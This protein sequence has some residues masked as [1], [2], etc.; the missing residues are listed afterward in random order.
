MEP[1]DISVLVCNYCTRTNIRP[2]GNSLLF[3][4]VFYFKEFPPPSS[5]YPLIIFIFQMKGN[6][7]EREREKN[8]APGLLIINAHTQ[9]GH[10]QL[11]LISDPWCTIRYHRLALGSFHLIEPKSGQSPQSCYH[12][13][14]L[15][16]IQAAPVPLLFLA[17]PKSSV[18][19]HTHPPSF[20][21]ESS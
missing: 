18:P 6:E 3:Y 15:L 9:R 11:D 17:R 10:T 14:F 13:R 8:G 2:L 5:S 21:I 19:P 7:R 12:S 16:N 20:C 4:F 1:A